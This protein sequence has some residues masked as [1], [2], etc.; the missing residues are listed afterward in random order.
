LR[1]PNRNKKSTLN[2]IIYNKYAWEFFGVYCCWVSYLNPTYKLET[3]RIVFTKQTK[4]DAR[5]IARSG[6][7]PQAE[8]LIEI[9]KKILI[10]HLLLMKNLLVILLAPAPEESTFN[11]AWFT[12]SLITSRLL[13]SFA[14]GRIMNRN[15]I[16]LREEAQPMN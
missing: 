8:K 16:G 13:K 14:Y 11:I 5:K 9:L 2:R 12:R 10:R 1:S 3:W 4:N 6:I 15:D 7:K